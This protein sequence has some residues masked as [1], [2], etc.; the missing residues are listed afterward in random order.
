[1]ISPALSP[2]NGNVCCSWN[3]TLDSIFSRVWWLIDFSAECLLNNVSP[4]S[5]AHVG[6]SREAVIVDRN[7]LQSGKNGGLLCSLIFKKNFGL[8]QKI[9]AHCRIT[10]ISWIKWTGHSSKRPWTNIFVLHQGN[11]STAL[12]GVALCR[13]F[14]KNVFG[15]EKNKLDSRLSRRLENTRV[16][17]Y[18]NKIL[19]IKG[20]AKTPANI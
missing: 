10:C 11:N 5:P 14:Y 13:L 9:K 3:P 7:K 18:S 2:H 17:D 20:I 6:R 4:T 19:K 8:N 16:F 15:Q 1:M 12:S